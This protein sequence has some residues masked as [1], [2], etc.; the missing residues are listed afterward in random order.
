MVKQRLKVKTNTKENIKTRTAV[1]NIK[2]GH[3]MK[4]D[5]SKRVKNYDRPR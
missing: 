2:I 5:D 4:M 3:L 1:Y